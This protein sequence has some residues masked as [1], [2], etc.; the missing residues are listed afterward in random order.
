MNRADAAQLAEQIRGYW[1]TRGYIL[2]IE[3]M[4]TAP[5]P[6]KGEGAFYGVQLPPFTPQGWP[7]AEYRTRRFRKA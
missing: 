2:P 4:M 1:V 3:V 7:P 5:A 6:H